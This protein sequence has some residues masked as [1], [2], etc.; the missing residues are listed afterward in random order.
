ML[1]SFIFCLSAEELRVSHIQIEEGLDLFLQP[2]PDVGIAF[3]SFRYNIGKTQLPGMPHF[4]EHLLFEHTADGLNYDQWLEAAGGYSKAHTDL[5]FLRLQAYVPSESVPL[6]LHLEGQRMRYLCDSLSEEAIQNQKLIVIQESINTQLQAAPFH[7]HLLRQAIFGDHPLGMDVLGDMFALTFW[8]KEEVCSFLRNDL[9]RF[10]LQVFV[11]GDIDTDSL[12][13]QTTL[14]FA[15]RNRTALPVYETIPAQNVHLETEGDTDALYAMWPIPAADHPDS[16]ALQLWHIL[17]S[18]SQIGRLKHPTI[19]SRGWIEQTPNGG[20]LVLRLE[21]DSP[22]ALEAHL[23]RQWEQVFCPF[24]GITKRNIDDA[25]AVQHRYVVHAQQRLEGRVKRMEYCVDRKS[26][27]PCFQ[28]SAITQRNLRKVWER[29]FLWE[30][31]SFLTVRT[32]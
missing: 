32:P 14:E 25:H 11:V 10:P 31:A 19:V 8:E 16:T 4:F 2:I 20:Y 23:K 1:F 30:K 15:G 29:W 21:G 3:V 7:T 13:Q 24:W 26:K 9:N 6:L 18:H 28:A 12:V 22:H 27:Y 17:L 5:S